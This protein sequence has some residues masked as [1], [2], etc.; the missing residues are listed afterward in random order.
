MKMILSKNNIDQYAVCLYNANE[1]YVISRHK[2]LHNQQMA[3]YIDVR[4]FKELEEL[5]IDR[6]LTLAVNEGEYGYTVSVDNEDGGYRLI[7]DSK[8]TQCL[9]N[10]KVDYREL[11]RFIEDNRQVFAIFSVV[12]N[13]YCN[14]S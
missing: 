7:G 5:L 13:K 11:K 12:Y 1:F 4:G 9:G 6:S 10:I 8:Y 3:G 14:S 2:N